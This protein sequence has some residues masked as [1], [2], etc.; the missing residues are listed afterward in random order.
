M[1][2]L[3]TGDVV[4]KHKLTDGRGGTIGKILPPE[5]G[6]RFIFDDHRDAPRGFGLRITAAG[7]RAFIL[8]Y[9]FEGTQRRMTI[10]PWPTWSLVAA[11][12][13]AN[14]LRR[15]IDSGTDPLQAARKRAAVPTVKKAVEAY[16]ESRVEGLKSAKAITRY[17]KVDLCKSVGS[18]KVSDVRRRD[19]IDAVEAKAIETPTAARHLLGCTKTFFDWCVDREYVEFNPAASIRPKSI[20]P[21]GRKNTLAPVHRERVLDH[22]EIR[23]FWQTVDRNVRKQT[24]LALKLILVTGQRP[25]EVAGMHCKEIRNGVWTIP[26]A[27]RLKTETDHTVPLSNLA[28]DLIAQAQDELDRLARRRGWKPSG[29][30]FETDEA[31]HVT[32]TSLA[33]AVRRHPAAMNNRDHATWGHWRPHDLRRTARTEIA[34]CGFAEEIAERVIGHATRGMIAVYNQHRYDAE[35]RAALEAWQR[36]LESI[37]AGR[38]AD[39]SKVITLTRGASL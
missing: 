22:D 18:L 4:A 17:L 10:G 24:A 27:R 26:A 6:Q 19:L 13:E 33:Q 2:R 20:A 1:T 11:R 25:G 37:V 35:K 16:L 3:L 23:M 29:L 9:L 39:T 36:R 32:T 21:G 38:D 14:M 30:V 15:M 34:A 5:K 12:D 8:K 31:A 7:G 28:A